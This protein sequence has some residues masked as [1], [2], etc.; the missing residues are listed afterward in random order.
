VTWRA[1][2]ELK[3]II[4]QTLEL[5]SLENGALGALYHFD[6]DKEAAR[7]RYERLLRSHASTSQVRDIAARALVAL[8]ELELNVFALTR[9]LIAKGAIA[10]DELRKARSEVEALS[11]V[12]RKGLEGKGPS[13]TGQEE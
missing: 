10:P 1:D 12:Y 11:E 9:A 2:E 7:E 5:W 3:R 13:R 6:S 4:E 8:H